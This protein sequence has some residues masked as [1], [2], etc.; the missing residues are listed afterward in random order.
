MEMHD[1]VLRKHCG[2]LCL[3]ID[4]RIHRSTSQRRLL[5]SAMS[6]LPNNEPGPA[7]RSGMKIGDELMAIGGRNVCGAKLQRVIELLQASP[8]V[9]VVRVARPA[10][11]VEGSCT[12]PVVMF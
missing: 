10:P 3:A 6:T 2:M 1:L 11:P 9:V 4:E 7:Q 8:D 12:E 5:V